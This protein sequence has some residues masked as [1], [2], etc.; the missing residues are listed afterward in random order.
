MGFSGNI[1]AF[2]PFKALDLKKIQ[3]I[4][5]TGYTLYALTHTLLWAYVCDDCV[6]Y[7]AVRLAYKGKWCGLP[8]PRCLMN[9]EGVQKLARCTSS[10]HSCTRIRFWRKWGD[11]LGRA[12][13]TVNEC[14]LLS[15]RVCP[16]LCLTKSCFCMSF[17]SFTSCMSNSNLF[18]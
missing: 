8:E 2:L 14:L 6:V 18:S 11:K 10:L 12:T 5:L 1:V 17:F 3:F 13:L 9:V 15:A 16:C 4:C 7:N